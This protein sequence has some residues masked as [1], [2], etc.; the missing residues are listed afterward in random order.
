MAGCNQ[1][2]DSGILQLAPEAVL[3]DVQPLLLPGTT[4]MPGVIT[5]AKEPSQFILPLDKPPRR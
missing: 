4:R 3:A 1:H 2:T 5:Y